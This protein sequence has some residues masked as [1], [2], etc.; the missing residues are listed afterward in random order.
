MITG[1]QILLIVIALV[2]I[3]FLLDIFSF[4]SRTMPKFV[5]RATSK[6]KS[7]KSTPHDEVLASLVT[8]M[9]RLGLINL[10]SKAQEKSRTEEK[11]KRAAFR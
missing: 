11:H 5:R 4:F 9:E 2:A 6:E 8:E 1:T 10:E 7:V 3:S